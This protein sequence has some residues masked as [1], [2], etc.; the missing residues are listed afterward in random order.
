MINVLDT[1]GWTGIK[2]FGKKKTKYLPID[3]SAGDRSDYAAILAAAT[4][5]D[6]NAKTADTAIMAPD[7]DITG[8]KEIQITVLT[9]SHYY[10]NNATAKKYPLFAKVPATIP[11]SDP[12]I[13]TVRISIGVAATTP[14]VI[15]V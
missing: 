10:Y 6:S 11:V 3:S 14:G 15:G 9:D 4:T 13:N 8:W 1:T 7:V 5:A 2:S 12:D